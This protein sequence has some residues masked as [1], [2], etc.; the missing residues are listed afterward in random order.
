MRNLKLTH[1]IFDTHG[2]FW[3]TDVQSSIFA[4]I[5]ITLKNK[6]RQLLRWSSTNDWEF[7]APHK[8]YTWGDEECNHEIEEILIGTK[9]T[10]VSGFQNFYNNNLIFDNRYILRSLSI[11]DDHGEQWLVQ[12]EADETYI[13]GDIT[14]SSQQ[15][16]L[17]IDI[18]KSIQNPY[19]LSSTTQHYILA[20]T[21]G[22]RIESVELLFPEKFST[23]DSF[24]YV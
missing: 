1:D 17:P 8:V 21:I 13:S 24:K 5:E 3:V 7:I 15:K 10:G 9:L 14:P 22:R 19:D 18:S 2:P 6:Q 11:D 23:I 16:E 20:S 4:N 12:L